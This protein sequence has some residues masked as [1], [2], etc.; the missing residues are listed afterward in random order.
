MVLVL[1]GCQSPAG[2]TTPAP[3]S[4]DPVAKAREA[5]GRREWSV[6][7]PLLREA[8]VQDPDDLALHYSLAVAAT[9]TGGRDEAIQEFH[10]VLAH[11][12]RGSAERDAARSWLVA[13]GVLDGNRP[14]PLPP[15]PGEARG[16]SGISGSVLWSE[17]D[18]PPG[19]RVREQLH[20]IGIPEDHTTRD[21]RYIG[22][23]DDLGHYAFTGVVAGRYRLTNRIAGVPTWRLLVTLDAGRETVLD[24]TPANGLSARDDFPGTR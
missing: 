13:A 23:T 11:A 17:G 1:A 12:P 18:Q 9:H 5:V 3:G 4:P 14:R 2:P 7:A 22:R 16:D 10:W 15:V 19:P 24:L 6:A 20:L 8:L 21:L